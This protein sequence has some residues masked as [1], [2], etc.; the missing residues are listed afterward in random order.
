[1]TT[2]QCV[3]RQTLHLPCSSERGGWFFS[4]IAHLALLLLVSG[5][6]WTPP[7]Q[8]DTLDKVIEI[9]LVPFAPVPPP[10]P[11]PAP[12]PPAVT[13]IVAK[14]RVVAPP[15]RSQ[16][17]RPLVPAPS[18]AIPVPA[19]STAIPDAAAEPRAAAST[20]PTAAAGEASPAQRDMMVTGYAAQILDAVERRKT[21]PALSVNRGEEDTITVRLVVSSTGELLD[22][23]ATAGTH[24]RLIEA[25][26]AAV[27][28]A[29]P[30]PAFPAELGASSLAF[31]LPV[32]YRLR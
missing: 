26:L 28:A 23:T 25:S 19:P 20:V 29:A 18:A 31:N 8:D 24:H 2:E 16:E 21:Y 3:S 6:V 13:P 17:A 11:A 27:R 22:L 32:V 4:L 9:T 30:F 5:L 14:P 1:M 10:Q 7:V 15:T 12:A